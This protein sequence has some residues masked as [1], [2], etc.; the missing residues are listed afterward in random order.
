[1]IKTQE[2]SPL[3]LHGLLFL[4]MI[5]FCLHILTSDSQ[6]ASRNVTVGTVTSSTGWGYDTNLNDLRLKT[7]TNSGVARN[8][9][10]TANPY[11]VTA[12]TDTAAATHPWL[13]QA[14]GYAY[15]LADR[16]L[17]ATQP[18]PG[19]NAFA[20]DKLDNATTV[21]SPGAPTV[22]PTY[23]G[24]NQLATWGTQTFTYDDNGNTVSGDGT[25]TYQWDGANRLAEIAYVG[26][27]DKTV[28]TY[29]GLGRR[30]VM[31]D[32]VAGVTTTTRFLWCGERICQS[33]NGSDTVLARYFPE[34]EY[35]SSGTKKYVYQTDQLGS[36]RDVIDAATGTRVAAIDYGPYGNRTRTNGTVTP[37]YEYAGLFY[38]PKS[39]LMLSATRAYDT[40]TGRWLNRDPI[41]EAGGINLYGYVG[42]NP[43]MWIDPDGRSPLIVIGAVIGGVSGAIGAANATGGWNWS[44]A[45]TIAAGAVVGTVFGSVG[46]VPIGASGFGLFTGAV[47][48]AFAGYGGDVA[49]QLI[50]HEG[51][52]DC[53]NQGEAVF[54]G[55][56]GIGGA[57][58]GAVPNLALDLLYGPIVA[59]RWG[60]TSA[61]WSGAFS[62]G[63]QVVLPNTL[64]G[65]GLA[66]QSRT[67][68]PPNRQQR[69]R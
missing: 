37:G 61:L 63:T 25:K 67:G 41:G 13:T 48:G 43:V 5:F 23:N 19:N 10:V 59:A 24:F 49:G 2:H 53:V 44:N 31:A 1:M 54:Q 14:H 58:F 7:I 47:T 51:R 64:G 32:T 69:A 56:M 34:G 55:A 9:A 38:H 28:F 21:T 12:M 50:A 11:Q 20:Y 17:T 35:I 45:G 68:A 8:Y 29:D 4:T 52:M 60:Y 3:P 30:T 46:A 26:G 62:I 42:G 27:T 40:G 6:P 33:R 66:D 15:D 22:N 36:V 65:W 57:A 16:L 18:T 39:G